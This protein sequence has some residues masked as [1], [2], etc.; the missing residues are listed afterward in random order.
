MGIDFQ[1]VSRNPEGDDEIGYKDLDE[2]MMKSNKLIINT[3]PLGMFPEVDDFPPLPYE[4]ITHSHFL[5]DLIYNPE[6]TLFLKKG[7]EKGARTQ[8]GLEMLRLQA[9]KSWEI[10]NG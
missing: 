6:E 5:F 10:W 2:W 8:N 4:Y 1:F 3:T 7:K 9:E